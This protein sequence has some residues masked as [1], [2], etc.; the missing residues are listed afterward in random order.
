ME[1]SI[2]DEH[3]Y[4]YRF[5]AMGFGNGREIMRSKEF[6]KCCEKASTLPESNK[7][8]MAPSTFKKHDEKDS[9]E[10]SPKIIQ[11]PFFHKRKKIDFKMSDLENAAEDDNDSDFVE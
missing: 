11:K 3:Y 1:K 9:K 10:D 5:L 7:K 4:E 8:R 2:W 6:K